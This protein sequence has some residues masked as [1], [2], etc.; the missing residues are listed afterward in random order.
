MIR[1]EGTDAQM[2]ACVFEALLPQV[3]EV[4]QSR[5]GGHFLITSIEDN[6]V[7][8]TGLP[9]DAAVGTT[10]GYHAWLGYDFGFVLAHAGWTR[11]S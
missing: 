5:F 11:L 7:L 2:M 10:T 4:W 3:G 9:Q 1:E 8:A 6:T